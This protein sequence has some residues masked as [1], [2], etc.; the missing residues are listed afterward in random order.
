MPI[1]I[2]LGSNQNPNKGSVPKAGPVIGIDL[3]TTHSLVAIVENEKSKVIGEEN[4]KIVP[5]VVAYD[6]DGNVMAIGERA[7]IL[8]GSKSPHQI[9]YSVKRLMGR[10]IEDLKKHNI[11]LPYSIVDD[12]HH[13]QA[14]INVGSK[15]ISP[16]EVSSAI[17]KEL[18][19]KAER[20]LGQQVQR[21][22]VT[23]P[24]YF[25]DGQRSATKA[26]MRL[27]GLETVRIVNEP[28]AAALAYGWSHTHPGTVAVYDLG[29]G[30]F[31][32]SILKISN[33]VFEV[34]STS[35]DTQ[36]GGD[37]LDQAIASFLWNKHLGKSQPGSDSESPLWAQ[38]LIQSE[39]IKKA[40][41]DNTDYKYEIDG[42]G[43][44]ILT[45]DE[46][47]T[48]WKPFVEKTLT[49]C[50]KALQDA[51]LRPEEL[52]DVLLV[53]GSTRMPFVQKTVKEFFAKEPNTK[54]NPDEAV[55][56]GA[57]LQA[58]ILS[59]RGGDRLLL[60]VIPLSLGI[61]TMGGVVS[62]LIHR[63]S[64]IPT[65]AREVYT[66]HAEKQTS[67]DIHVLQGEREL[68]KDCR[69]LASFKLRGLTPAPPGFH[70]IEILFRID[71]NGILN[72][73]AKDLRSGKEREIEV[74]PSFGLS[75]DD[76]IKMLESSYENAESDM[77]SRQLAEIKIEADS[78]IRA[79]EIAMKNAGSELEP[80][81]RSEIQARLIDLKNTKSSQNLQ[82]ITQ[83]IELLNEATK[84]LAEIQ[85][86]AALGKA[87]R[88]TRA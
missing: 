78:I 30:T 17:L 54:L 31:D 88:G 33:N 87:L 50:Q 41:G 34:L 7:R 27:A 60:D 3:G 38:T 37:D 26:A 19:K 13:T 43:K 67:F 42:L 66:N 18:K 71:A 86:N 35:G 40:L 57:A 6:T 51:N 75:D 32:I 11:H 49:C 69:S 23:V 22:V 10:N 28:T 9:L 8:K 85:V 59:G 74:L 82:K 25:D 47:E 1:Q 81:N 73:R 62:K 65:E 79:T 12:V 56:L 16:I 4:S 46:A 61:E 68:V 45:R 24:A 20:H 63:N 15:S 58:E 72:V 53:G 70:R 83:A 80:Q 48:L 36:L 14:L 2:D 55:A 77:H 76:L 44:G 39:T 29:G 21:A 64:T 52:D 84:E 5:S